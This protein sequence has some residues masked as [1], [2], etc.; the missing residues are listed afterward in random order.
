MIEEIVLMHDINTCIEKKD[1]ENISRLKFYNIN[2]YYKNINR[3]QYFDN[4]DI[5]INYY[6]DFSSNKLSYNTE[7]YYNAKETVPFCIY[8]LDNGFTCELPSYD[9]IINKIQKNNIRYMPFEIILINKT[10]ESLHSVV[11]VFDINELSLTI[12][13]SNGSLDYFSNI[14]DSNII[15]KVFEEYSKY[16]N[17]TYKITN[18]E[19]IN[20]NNLNGIIISGLC[21]GWTLLFIKLLNNTDIDIDILIDYLLISNRDNL[22]YNFYKNL[23]NIFF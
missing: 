14:T 3:N 18:I 7:T 5:I 2:N 15:H 10:L 16:I 6:F 11:L 9:T 8:V 1:I 4:N 12:I 20:S 23:K 17:F 19:N 21:R 22:I 13:D